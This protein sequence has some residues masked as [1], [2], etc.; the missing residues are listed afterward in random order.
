[1][2]PGKLLLLGFLCLCI[3][4][5]P[6][7]ARGQTNLLGLRL[8]AGVSIT[9]AVASVYAIQASTNLAKSNGWT[10][11]AFVQLPATN[12]LWI[13]TTSPSAG[14]RFYRALAFAPTNLVFIP[15]GTFRMGSPT[16]EV[17]RSTDEGP[18][19]AVT[20]TKGFYLG[21][22]PV[23]QGDY[24]AVMGSNPSHFTGNTNRPVEEVSWIDATNYCAKRTQQEA[25]AGLIPAGSQYR[26]PTE[27]E[28][29]YA[30]RAWTST[31]F[32]YGDDPGYTN[33]VNYAWY[34]AN[35]GSTTQP[36]GQKLPNEWGSYDMAGNVWEWCQDWYGPYP[37][38]TAIDPQGP[39][40]GSARVN[41]GGSWFNAAAFCRSAQRSSGNPAGVNSNIGFRIV[42]AAQQ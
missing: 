30:C 40:V 39:S 15:P 5:N 10:C 24:M 14:Q 8:Y 23:T 35:A 16:N 27:A 4:A 33:L 9:G 17:G 3:G 36:V 21:Q 28:W 11:L 7:S 19:T 32:Y 26:L 13:D 38:G 31:R 37:G 29:E 20:I 12:Y 18:Q 6:A 2:K 41:R 42:L 22:Y 34:S 25:A 1:M